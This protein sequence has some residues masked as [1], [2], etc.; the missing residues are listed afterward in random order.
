M[1]SFVQILELRISS[2]ERLGWEHIKAVLHSVDSKLTET[3]FSLKIWMDSN[4]CSFLKHNFINSQC[5]GIINK[6]RR[7]WGVTL[8]LDV[9][10]KEISCEF[11]KNIL[12]QT[13][14]YNESSFD[15]LPIRW[16]P[17]ISLAE[18]WESK[19]RFGESKNV[20]V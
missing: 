10:T 1:S 11:A 19:Y 15:S 2:W 9:G 16:S 8:T 13:L 6:T 14:W 18:V 5:H 17:S 3:L 4:S 7:W 20:W 12:W